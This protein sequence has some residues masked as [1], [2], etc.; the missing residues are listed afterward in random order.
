MHTKLFSRRERETLEAWL[1]NKPC[2]RIYL[3]KVLY[4][5]RQPSSLEEDIRLLARV[6][7]RLKAKPSK[8]AST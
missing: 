7:R 5:L 1:S 4:R 8:A 2:D 6:K 3:S